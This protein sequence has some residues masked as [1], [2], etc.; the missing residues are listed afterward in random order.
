MSAIQKALLSSLLLAVVVALAKAEPVQGPNE[1]APRLGEEGNR[2][3]KKELYISEGEESNPEV[4]EDLKDLKIERCALILSQNRDLFPTLN[5]QGITP[6]EMR[7]YRFDTG[8]MSDFLYMQGVTFDN[9]KSSVFEF[10]SQLPEYCLI[11]YSQKY[12]GNIYNLEDYTILIAK[13]K[14][15]VDF[16]NF[17]RTTFYFLEQ[18]RYN[19]IQTGGDWQVQCGNFLQIIPEMLAHYAQYA[20]NNARYI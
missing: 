11:A 9:I 10:T 3:C 6:E 19:I 8:K 17:S 7:Q 2:L 12:Q 15:F 5:F 14:G 1:G 13:Y 4:P 18:C 20:R 16:I